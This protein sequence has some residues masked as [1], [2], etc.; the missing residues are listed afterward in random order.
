MRAV[1]EVGR[2]ARAVVRCMGGLHRISSIGLRAGRAAAD[3][4]RI[5]SGRLRVRR[6][7]GE[8][9]MCRPHPHPLSRT[10]LDL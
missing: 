1:I 2:H 7:T 10:P 5:G 9:G 3:G 4:M 8:G 6:R